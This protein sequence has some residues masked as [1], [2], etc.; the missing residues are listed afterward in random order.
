MPA[1][2]EASQPDWG[3]VPLP[4]L[5]LV[6]ILSEKAA[7]DSNH[8]QRIKWP[9]E[10]QDVSEPLRRAIS[11]AHKINKAS[12]DVRSLLSAYAHRFH[13]PRPVL[14]DLARAQGTTSQGFV[15]RY[16][17]VTV[18][19]IE[20]LL[21]EDPDLDAIRRAFPSVS[22]PALA[23]MTG[24]VGRAAQAYQDERS[25]VVW[26]KK[27]EGE[28]TSFDYLQRGISPGRTRTMVR[29][30][31]DDISKYTAEQRARADF[32][33]AIWDKMVDAKGSE[34]ARKWFV[35]MHPDLDELTPA[36]AIGSDRFDDVRKIAEEFLGS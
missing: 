30:R 4:I 21:S 12:N 8:L 34:V 3:R 10:P 5:E 25:P 28:M 27:P 33:A 17:E 13:Q 15:R 24:P 18:K 22:M 26:K 16:S 1:G 36:E 23:S 29:S 20:S 7:D 9:S 14:A 35:T 11:D 31:Q 2:T 6:R 19:G 32:A